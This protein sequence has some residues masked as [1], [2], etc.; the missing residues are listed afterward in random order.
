MQKILPSL[1][2]ILLISIGATSC[3]KDSTNNPNNTGNSPVANFSIGATTL[4]IG[5]EFSL[6]NE[7]KFSTDYKWEINGVQYSTDQDLYYLRLDS[8]G[9]YTIKLTAYDSIGR[10]NSI[11]K[12]VTVMN[13]FLAYAGTWD[14]TEREQ[15]SP[16]YTTNY[17]SSVSVDNKGQV[18]FTKFSENEVPVALSY[19]WGNSSLTHSV[20]N[21]IIDISSSYKIRAYILFSTSGSQKQFT[22]SVDYYQGSSYDFSTDISGIKQ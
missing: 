10:S 21:F 13:Q 9:T 3:K 12:T 17:V 6:T 20:D 15:N 14:I 11:T 18:S 5:T 1:T 8:A 22:G 19:Q 4:Y 16:Y 7:S 2:T